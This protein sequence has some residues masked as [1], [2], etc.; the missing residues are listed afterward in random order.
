M[1]V[2]RGEAKVIGLPGAD[3]TP[4]LLALEL[5]EMEEDLEQVVM[6][7]ILKDGQA[8]VRATYPCQGADLAWAGALLL[9]HAV[10]TE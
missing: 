7:Q 9:Q 10:T 1:G 3:N 4:G 6:V 8:R 5:Q 2:K